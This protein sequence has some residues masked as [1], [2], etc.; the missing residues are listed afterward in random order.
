MYRVISVVNLVILASRL[1]F[2]EEDMKIFPGFLF[3]F[4]EIPLH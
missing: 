1:D 3:T 4:Y 2:S